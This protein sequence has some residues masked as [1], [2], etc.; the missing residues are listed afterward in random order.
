VRAGISLESSCKEELKQAFLPELPSA[1]SCDPGSASTTTTSICLQLWTAIN[2]IMVN[3]CD[4]CA[5]ANTNQTRAFS[6]SSL[7]RFGGILH[8]FQEG[9]IK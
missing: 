7:R 6:A 9:F 8:H 3:T 1:F 2:V 4:V 5:A